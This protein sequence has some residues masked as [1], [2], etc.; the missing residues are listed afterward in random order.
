MEFSD[1]H[2]S[3]F[4]IYEAVMEA[5]RK[6]FGKVYSMRAVYEEVGMMTFLSASRVQHIVS[7]MLKGGFKSHRTEETEE[8]DKL[9]YALHSREIFNP[10]DGL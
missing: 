5:N 7:Q 8:L 2:Q 4:R 1:K 10:P 3:V 9:V 6:K